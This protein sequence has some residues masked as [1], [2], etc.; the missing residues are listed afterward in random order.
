M[1]AASAAASLYPVPCTS[2]APSAAASAASAATAIWV[3][4]GDHVARRHP[5]VYLRLDEA[6]DNEN[7]AERRIAEGAQEL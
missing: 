1:E 7:L 4:G 3:S 6:V 5:R 2:A